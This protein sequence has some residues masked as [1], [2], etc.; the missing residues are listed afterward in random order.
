MD[1]PRAT[2]RHL[3]TSGAPLPAAAAPSARRSPTSSTVVLLPVLVVVRPLLIRRPRC[4][5]DAQVIRRQGYRV[6][7]VTRVSRGSTW[8][9][10]SQI[11]HQEG[12]SCNGARGN[13][14]MVFCSISKL[15]P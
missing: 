1:A 15:A 11:D 3:T 7:R 13:H 14:D 2:G 6:T 10:I 5:D 8:K 9:T 12:K 4:L